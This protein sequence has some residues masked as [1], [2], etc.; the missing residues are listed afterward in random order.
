M[1]NLN[2]TSLRIATNIWTVQDA[3]IMARV[4]WILADTLEGFAWKY[5]LGCIDSDRRDAKLML[6]A[7]A[8][9]PVLRNLIR[10][11]Q[12]LTIPTVS[13]AADVCA[14]Y[15]AIIRPWRR[16]EFKS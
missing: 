15:G 11:S 9:E 6:E 10:L 3:R 13:I 5:I 1:T 4:A 2:I 7:H 12:T 16:R 14:S 8:C